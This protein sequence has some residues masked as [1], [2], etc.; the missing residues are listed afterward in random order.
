MKRILALALAIIL[1]FSLVSCGEKKTDVNKKYSSDTLKIYLPGEYLGEN[2]ISDFEKKLGVHVIVELFDSNEMMYTKLQ[3]GDKYDVL[4]PSDYMVERLM[5][6]DYL[7]KL[8]YT[9][10]P[11]TSAIYSKVPY[12]ETMKPYAVPYFWGSVGLVYNHN[13]V[14]KNDVES[15]GYGV[16]KNE[17]YKGKIYVYDSERDSFMMAFKNLGY[18]MNTDKEEEITAAYNWLCELDSTMEPIYVTD[19]V[20]D[21]MANGLKDIAVVYSGDAAYILSEN[22]DMSFFLPNEGTNFWT[23]YMVVPKNAANPELAHEFI[24]FFLEYKTAYD[25]SEYVGY[26]SPVEK[27][28]NDLANGEYKGNEAYV[29]REMGE[30]DEM[31]SYNSYLTKRLSELWVKVMAS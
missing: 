17:K 13:N 2:V 27:V 24:N 11:N 23:D 12:P 30:K 29:T 6:E 8:D 4:I 22:E 1:A 25:N 19:E 31:F 5:G 15:Q 18:S 28:Y 7:A 9:K 20:I 26:D 21:D 16:L 10:I 3:S 14:D